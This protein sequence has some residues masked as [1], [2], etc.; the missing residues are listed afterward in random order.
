VGGHTIEDFRTHDEPTISVADILVESS[1]VGAAVLAE[2]IGAEALVGYYASLGLFDA[3]PARLPELAQPQVPDRFGPAERAT[4]SFG[5]GLAVTP[6]HAAAA[7]AAVLTDGVYQAPRFVM[8]EGE[9]RLRG[10]RAVETGT[11]L[12]MRALARRVVTEGSGGH[13]AVPALAMLGK[14]GTADKADHGGYDTSRRVASFLAAYPGDRPQVVSLIVLDEPQPVH[15]RHPY[16]TAG[17][18]AA[19]LS[20]LL[21]IRVAAV[22]GLDAEAEARP[23]PMTAQAGG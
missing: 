19:P 7:A 12:T 9:T 20:K 5:H 6:L 8:A 21:A 10:Q 11:A 22:L 18:N 3:V 13:A 4:M 16:A 23:A 2:I 1:N 15:G 14:T 17:W